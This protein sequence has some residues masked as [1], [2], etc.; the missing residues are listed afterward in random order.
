ME[1][2][3]KGILNAERTGGI[4][5][6][7]GN[8]ESEVELLHQM[9]R[10][11][12]FGV[13]VGKGVRYMQNLFIKNGWGDPQ[14]IR[15]IG[16]QIKGLEISQYMSKESLAQ[17]GGYALANKGPQH[18]EAWLIFMDMVNNQIPTFEDKAEALH[19]FPLFRT[20]FGLQGLCKLPWN[21]IEPPD[22]HEKYPGPEAA[23]VP[24]HVDNYL[25]LYTGITGKP[26]DRKSLIEQSESVYN[27]QRVFNLRMGQGVREFDMPPYR[28]VGPVTKEEY[29]SRAERYDG[30]LKDIVGIDPA[31]KTTEEKMALHREWRMGRYNQLVDAVYKR[32]GWTPNGVPTMATLKKF[33]IDF[34]DVVAVVQPHL[35]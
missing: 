7:W 19:Y 20:W 28:A 33:K 13:T 18:D 2:W 8:G 14:Y 5:L 24:A 27:F 30:Q 16:M 26:L 15:D 11:E 35:T 31:G 17:Q 4:D 3:E 10:G 23:K 22:N 34:P 29:V 25:A 1:C 6:T 9:W 12:G 21:D 32:R